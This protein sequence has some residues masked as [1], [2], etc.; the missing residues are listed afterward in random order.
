MTAAAGAFEPRPHVVIVGAGI[1]GIAA[2][3]RIRTL[4]PDVLITVV[5]ATARIGGKIAGEVVAGCVVDGGADVCIGAKLR[6]TELFTQL[7]LEERVVTVNP[8]GLPSL[9]RRGHSLTPAPTRFTDELLTFPD[10]MR[11]LVDAACSALRDVT[12]VTWTPVT[13]I[14]RIAGAWNVHFGSGSYPGDA[15][16]LAVPADAAARLLSAVAPRESGALADLQCPPTTT[17]TMAWEQSDVPCPFDATGYMVTDPSDTVTACTWTSSKIPSHAAHGAALVRGYVR[18]SGDGASAAV[19]YEVRSTLGITA[20]P[21]FSRT[22]A[23]PAGIPVYTPAH[24]SAVA[25]L[26]DVLSTHPGLYVAGSAFHGVG[27]PDCIA[28][29]ERAA[30]AAVAHLSLL[31]ATTGT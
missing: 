21:L 9:E 26:T 22:Y 13:E 14:S 4:R 11:E 25:K 2:A 20:R 15:V 10:G 30:N 27:I 29:G 16:I 23:W 3:L 19:L 5:E 31:P 6:A 24:A 7:R 8:R 12:V 1:A 17:V 28:S 18:G